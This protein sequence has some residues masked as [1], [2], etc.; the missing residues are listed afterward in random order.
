[1]TLVTTSVGWFFTFIKK[2]SVLGLGVAPIYFENYLPN[3][4]QVL[5]ERN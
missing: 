1:M 4:V 5:A 3:L 2:T